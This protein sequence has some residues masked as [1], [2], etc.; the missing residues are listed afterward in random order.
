MA[1]S[2]NSNAVAYNAVKHPDPK[3]PTP[4]EKHHLKRPVL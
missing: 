4:E 1:P 2:W 3:I